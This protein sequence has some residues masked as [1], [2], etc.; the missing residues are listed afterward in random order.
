MMKGKPLK[1]DWDRLEEAFSAQN[2]ELVYYLDL[3]TGHLVLEGEGLHA[4]ED[5]DDYDVEGGPTPEPDHDDSTRAYVTP[6]DL[7]LK[8]EWMQRFVDEVDLGAEVGAD[9]RQA[10]EQDD[11]VAAIRDVLGRHA[12]G[13]D[14]WYLYRSDRLHELIESWLAEHNVATVDPPPWRA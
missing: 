9:F 5:D 14:R 7:Q 8:I 12:E 3:V 6:P 1:L 10:L 11:P 4:A 13:R 2:E